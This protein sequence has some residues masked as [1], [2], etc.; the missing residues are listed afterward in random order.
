MLSEF[1]D[2][3]KL[4]LESEETPTKDY[5]ISIIT[6]F[7]NLKFIDDYIE[8]M[9]KHVVDKA[10]NMINEKTKI[11]IVEQSCNKILGEIIFEIKTFWNIFGSIMLPIRNYSPIIGKIYSDMKDNIKIDLLDSLFKIQ[12]R[13]PGSIKLSEFDVDHKI[14]EEYEN[15]ING[16]SRLLIS[17]EKL[18]ALE[19]ISDKKISDVNWSFM[20]L[21]ITSVNNIIMNEDIKIYDN[22]KKENSMIGKIYSDMYDLIVTDFIER[23]NVL[24]EYINKTSSVSVL[25]DV[26][27]NDFICAIINIILFDVYEDLKTKFSK[28]YKKYNLIIDASKE[29]NKNSISYTEIPDEPQRI[30]GY[31]N[32]DKK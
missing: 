16:F 23:I 9:M 3:I 2:S 22:I 18:S 14:T 13:F 6:I 10:N 4:Q 26:R 24:Y 15:L 20:T 17:V 5:M 12:D 28:Y 31:I 7:D 1:D 19:N 32:T 11:E 30:I 25:K 21:L 29:Q 27:L 8:C